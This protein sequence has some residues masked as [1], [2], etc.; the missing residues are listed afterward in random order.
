LRIESH[1]YQ[2]WCLL[3]AQVVED[4]H[5]SKEKKASKSPLCVVPAPLNLLTAVASLMQHAIK[6]FSGRDIKLVK[7]TANVIFAMCVNFPC[8]VLLHFIV[9][10]VSTLHLVQYG[11]SRRFKDAQE[12]VAAAHF[13]VVQ[14]LMVP[15]S[16]ILSLYYFM[17]F[18]TEE[19][20]EEELQ[21]LQMRFRRHRFGG[22][23]STKPGQ[24]FVGRR[25]S[26]ALPA[27]AWRPIAE[28]NS[29]GT[30]SV[31]EKEVKKK[32]NDKL[33]TQ[34]FCRRGE[35]AAKLERA[36]INNDGVIARE[37]F[38]KIVQLLGQAE[39]A[40]T[41]ASAKPKAGSELLDMQLKDI[42]KLAEINAVV[43][44]STEESE[45]TPETKLAEARKHWKK[46][47]DMVNAVKSFKGD[48]GEKP[49]YSAPLKTE[50][51]QV[52]QMRYF[53]IA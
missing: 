7:S 47:S 28:T 33:F 21:G 1:S 4:Y 42:Q 49:A 3:V 23:P 18:S 26:T 14:F 34:L 25:L 31:A 51:A 32:E 15:L 36:D 46:V 16:P 2:E 41:T 5:Q 6:H 20:K 24:K 19:E 9:P 12:V 13:I 53:Y 44:D 35:L 29:D 52:G 30:M 17:H 22:K 39:V 45:K 38:Y 11:L 37:D 10:V 43:V 50:K 48:R 8:T 27:D 40:E